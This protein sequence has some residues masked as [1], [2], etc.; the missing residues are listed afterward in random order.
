MREHTQQMME[1]SA[2]GCAMAAARQHGAAKQQGGSQNPHTSRT[3]AALAMERRWLQV[4]DADSSAFRVYS[5]APRFYPST[6][7]LHV[8]PGPTRGCQHTVH[9]TIATHPPSVGPTMTSKDRTG[10]QSSAPHQSLRR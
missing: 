6:C 7:L 5:A 3:S 8:L 4:A 10:A 9:D 1:R 2:C